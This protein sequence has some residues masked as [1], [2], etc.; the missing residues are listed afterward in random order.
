[1]IMRDEPS[2]LVIYLVSYSTFKVSWGS[3]PG[4]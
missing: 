2:F 3:W 4:R 1:M